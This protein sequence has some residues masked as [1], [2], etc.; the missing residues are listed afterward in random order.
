MWEAYEAQRDLARKMIRTD[1]ELTAP[2]G[3]NLHARKKLEQ[4]KD[5]G[6]STVSFGGDTAPLKPP[7]AVGSSTYGLSR[8]RSQHGKG[9]TFGRMLRKSRAGCAEE[10][11]LTTRPRGGS[12]VLKV[13]MKRLDVPGGVLDTKILANC[14]AIVQQTNC[15][16]CHPAGLAEGI[17]KALPYGCSYKQRRAEPP[18][19]KFAVAADRSEPGTI[20][21]RRP[22][23]DASNSPIVI[24]MF[25]QWELGPALKYNRVPCPATYGSD[26]SANREIWF[27]RCLDKIAALGEEKPSSIAFPYEIA[28]AW[29]EAD[30]LGTKL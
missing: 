11:S 19:R 22:P 6:E 1:F 7:E 28:V 20:D 16:G 21:F 12:R 18:A 27:Q 30:G 23:P 8:L 9:D 29:L 10:V 5:R 25:A 13:A 14:Q 15:I 17:A 26:S 2:A 4:R 3:E 24:N